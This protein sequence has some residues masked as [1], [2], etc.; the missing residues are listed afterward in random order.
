MPG[1][2][3]DETVIFQRL[4][5]IGQRTNGD[6]ALASQALL[7]RPAAAILVGAIGKGHEDQ[8]AAS[9]Q[10]LVAGFQNG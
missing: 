4:Q 3:H 10:A 2:A 8:L 6:A 9:G 7:R 5:V 1:F